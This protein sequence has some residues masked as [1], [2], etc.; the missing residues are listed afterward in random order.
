[1]GR[2]LAPFVA[3]A[4]VAA[5]AAVFLPLVAPVDVHVFLRAGSA[6]VH[7]HALYPHVGTAAVYSGSSFVYPYL[8]AWPFVP[9]SLLSSGVASAL[10]FL[11]CVAA[12]IAAVRDPRDATLV[13]C[14]AFTVT[15]L[16]LGALS[17]LLFAGAL[18]M[19]RL[20]DRP[21]AFALVAA[22][23]V[24]SKL[25]LAP[26]LLWPLAMRRYRAFG[27]ACC[28]TLLV[29][30]V[31][32]ALGPIGPGTY[33]RLLSALGSH[34]S[35]SGFGLVG[36]LRN[37]LGFGAGVA[38]AVAF[39]VAAG[40]LAVGYVR[41][42]GS[43]RALFSVS[44]VAALIA[45]PVL[46]SHYLVLVCAILLLLDVSRRWLL[47]LAVASW[48][49]APPHN[50]GPSSGVGY[51]ALKVVIWMAALAIAYVPGRGAARAATE[52]A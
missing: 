23:V 49:I 30:G 7:G 36:A 16:Q 51:A 10:G 26:L 8:A 39:V 13:L 3:V 20:R 34:E 37:Y 41:C 4:A 24:A 52:P 50:F 28:A 14:T 21:V 45:T 2:R 27:W 9:L 48:A 32:F 31:G 33:L 46:W 18:F 5:I 15:G 19:W 29:L 17:P 44:L 25:F 11:L 35:R 40:V 38:Q 12:I 47:V 1:M 42:R 43:D 22:V 6:L